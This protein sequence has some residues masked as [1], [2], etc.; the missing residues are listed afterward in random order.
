MTRPSKTL[1]TNGNDIL[2]RD[3]EHTQRA[4]LKKFKI[5]RKTVLSRTFKW[6]FYYIMYKNIFNKADNVH[7]T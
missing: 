3:T 4:F 7:T 6:M 1:Q 2:T 5:T